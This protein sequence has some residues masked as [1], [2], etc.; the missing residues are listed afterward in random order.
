MWETHDSIVADRHQE[1][2]NKNK[3]KYRTVTADGV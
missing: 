3:F 1:L 2:I